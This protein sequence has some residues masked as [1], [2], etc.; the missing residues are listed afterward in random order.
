MLAWSLQL[1]F[2][3]TVVVVF[4]VFRHGTA[5][6]GVATSPTLTNVVDAADQASLRSKSLL[7]RSASRLLGSIFWGKLILFSHS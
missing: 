3:L 7:P 5:F 1:S 4:V 6:L 2:A